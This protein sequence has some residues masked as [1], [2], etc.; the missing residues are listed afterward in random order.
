MK[1][2]ASVGDG[3]RRCLS[4]ELTRKPTTMTMTQLQQLPVAVTVFA[5]CSRIVSI[6]SSTTIP[7]VGVTRGIWTT[8]LQHRRCSTCDV[9]CHAT[10]VDIE[11]HLRQEVKQ[12]F[13]KE[14]TSWK[15]GINAVGEIDFYRQVKVNASK[16]HLYHNKLHRFLPPWISPDTRIKM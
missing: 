9:A 8:V 13:V 2:C 4:F 11:H 3:A 10:G 7:P 6:K 1:E 12:N 15:K 16:C 5:Q 14:G